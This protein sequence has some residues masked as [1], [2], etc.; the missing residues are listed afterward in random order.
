MFFCLQFICIINPWYS[1]QCYFFFSTPWL[2]IHLTWMNK[3]HIQKQHWNVFTWYWIRV[4]IS[5]LQILEIWN[6]WTTLSLTRLWDHLI[7]LVLTT[8]KKWLW[9]YLGK[10]FIFFNS[11]NQF[12]AYKSIFWETK[13]KKKFTRFLFSSKHLLHK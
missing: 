13:P 11:L 1:L 6:I 4:G 2:F 9:L 5:I 12:P 3:I 7:E 10:V 8:R